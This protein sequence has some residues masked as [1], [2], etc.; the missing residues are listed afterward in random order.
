[1]LADLGVLVKQIVDTASQVD[2][3]SDSNVPFETVIRGAVGNG[4]CCA[5]P[6]ELT[7]RVTDI[8]NVIRSTPFFF[9]KGQR[10]VGPRLGVT[11]VATFT[12]GNRTR[13]LERAFRSREPD[14]KLVEV[15][16][17]PMVKVATDVAP[18]RWN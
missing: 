17:V 3:I 8:A 16:K 5:E 4:C 9:V 1:M 12:I 11:S 7:V 10:K 18:S 6:L 15:G 13:Q 14:I 2:V